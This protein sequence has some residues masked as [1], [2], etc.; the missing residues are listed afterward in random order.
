MHQYLITLQFNT[1]DVFPSVREMEKR[2][3]E[4]INQSGF[5]EK[6]QLH[7]RLPVLSLSTS[8]LLSYA[9][10]DQIAEAVNEHFRQNDIPMSCCEVVK[11]TRTKK[12]KPRTSV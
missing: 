1:G 8:R 10:Q 9:E 5:Q 4:F 3:N 6:I 11:P 7:T 12:T 2:I